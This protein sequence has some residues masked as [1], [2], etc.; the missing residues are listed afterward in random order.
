[1]VVVYAYINNN[2]KL[3]NNTKETNEH[4]AHITRH[5]QAINKISQINNEQY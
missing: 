3:I 5:I 1:M 2:I 4:L